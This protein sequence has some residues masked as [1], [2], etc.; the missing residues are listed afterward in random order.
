MKIADPYWDT[1]RPSIWLILFFL[2]VPILANGMP[3]SSIPVVQIGKLSWDQSE[4]TIKDVQIYASA[5]GFMSQAEKN[6]GGLSY[7]AGFVKKPG[8]NWKT[9]YGVFAN[10]EEPA[11]HLNQNEAEKI[12]RFFGKR[13]PTDD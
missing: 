3:K 4:M 8:W 11:V 9:P 1:F 6:G 13:F 12:C 10:E 7:E 2:M 5:T